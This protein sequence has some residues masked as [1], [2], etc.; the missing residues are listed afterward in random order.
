[1]FFKKKK[2]KEKKKVNPQTNGKVLFKK[3]YNC[4][5]IKERQKLK[6]LNK[7]M[8]L[9]PKKKKKKNPRFEKVKKDRMRNKITNAAFII[10]IIFSIFLIAYLTVNFITNIRGGTTVED[11]NYQSTYVEGFSSIP[12]F[13]RSEFVY[14]HRMEDEIV[15]KMLS[16]GISVYR[17]PPRTQSEEIYEYYREQLPE[18]G[19]EKL[20]TV[21]VSTDES[22]FG[23][24]WAKAEKG[25]RIYVENNDIWYETIS[26]KEAETSL[27]ERREEELKRKR[28][29]EASSDQRLL[30]D[31]PWYLEIPSEYLIVYTDSEIK[32][33]R[34]TK[35]YTL[36]EDSE[37]FIKPLGKAGDRTFD[38]YL[39][40]LEKDYQEQELEWEV[41]DRKKSTFRGREIYSFNLEIEEEEGEGIFINNHLN[42]HTYAI[43]T[44]TKDDEFFKYIIENITEP[45]F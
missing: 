37:Y 30:P 31:Y 8:V 14:Q 5:K 15:Q 27:A 20:E 43:L 42:D 45:Q 32:D 29:L 19:W 21:I 41:I 18:Y 34:T 44:N 16:K 25:L 26:R 22:L 6:T 17:Y 23:Q 28:I 24:Y 33:L 35:I 39:E 1:M 40:Q 4:P 7:G 11:I 38:E 12:I 13:P 2:D 36:A 10:L 9:K 3:K